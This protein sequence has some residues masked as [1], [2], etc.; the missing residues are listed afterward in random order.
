MSNSVTSW[1]VD[2]YYFDTYRVTLLISPLTGPGHFLILIALFNMWQFL[3]QTGSPIRWMSRNVFTFQQ[4]TRGLW[5]F[6]K[7]YFIACRRIRK[8]WFL[9]KKVE[10]ERL[11]TID[12]VS[13]SPW[14]ILLFEFF[15]CCFKN[16]SV[17]IDWH[18]NTYK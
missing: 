8:T 2:S 10:K 9:V 12:Y 11:H 6:Y 17:S 14:K 7:Q 3:R 1:D 4:H 18:T 16:Q 15:N 13:F 5:L